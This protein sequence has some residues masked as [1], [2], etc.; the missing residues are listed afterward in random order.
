MRVELAYG[1]HGL[2]INVPADATV[3]RPKHVPGVPDEAAAL[4]AALRSPLSSAPLRERVR[5]QDTVAILFSDITRP[6]PNDRVLPV[7][8]EELAH[9]PRERILLI[10]ATGTHRVQTHDELIEMLGAEI[11][12]GYRIAQHSAFDA[13]NLAEIG[14]TTHEHAVSVNRQYL[15]ASFRILTGFIEPHIFAGFSGGP[16]AILPGVAGIETIMDNHSAQMMASSKATWGVTEGNP[17]WEEMRE[18]A[19]LAQPSFLLNVTINAQRQL[20]RVFAGEWGA[21]HAQGVAFAREVAMTPVDAPY[22]IVITTNS[23]Y[24][25]DINLYQSAKGMSAAAQI[26]KQ[27]GSILMASECS[28]GIPEYGEYK[29]L[30]HEGGSVEGVMALVS[31][32]GFRRHD[33]W[34]AL[35]QARI[36]RQATVHLYADGLTPEQTRGMLFEPCADLQSTF[37]RLLHQ[38]GQNARVCVLP[39]GPQAIP[40]LC[41]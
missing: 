35:L 2:T 36:Q 37:E 12:H 21:A 25:L 4:R 28:E 20:T 3:L 32:P 39:E 15:A 5:P 6:M 1:R 18:A 16:K 40:Y 29:A 26:V 27:G 33:M 9:I 30:I 23:G 13:A 38:H 41:N 34:E 19:R 8:L 10:N 14:R 22:D 7:L 11:V 24:P 31:Q 17:V